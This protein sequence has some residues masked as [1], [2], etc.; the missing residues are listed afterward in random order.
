MVAGRPAS[1]QGVGWRFGST[2]AQ[3]ENPSPKKWLAS[4]LHTP[5]QP[6]EAQQG[7]KRYRPWMDANLVIA[8]SDHLTP[9]L[10]V[11][12]SWVIQITS[13]LSPSHLGGAAIVALIFSPTQASLE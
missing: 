1:G 9:D 13:S 11:L 2:D 12:V 6:L 4:L 5:L 8:P 7:P 3:M 10:A